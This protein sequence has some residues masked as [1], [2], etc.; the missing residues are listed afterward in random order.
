M[1][2]LL[3]LRLHSP[4]EPASALAMTLASARTLRGLWCW[5]SSSGLVL[6]LHRSSALTLVAALVLVR[7]RSSELASAA[8]LVLVRHGSSALAL[9]VALLF[10]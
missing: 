5:F 2:V 6:A 8:A 3:G 9:A 10:A 7:H 1:S 4:L